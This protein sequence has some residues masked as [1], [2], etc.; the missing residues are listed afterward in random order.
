ML[1]F[2]YFLTDRAI[3]RDKNML[4]LKGHFLIC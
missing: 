1:F 3:F 4:F 2:F